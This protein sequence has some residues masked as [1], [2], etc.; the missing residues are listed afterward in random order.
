MIEKLPNEIP[1]YHTN[2]I[3]GTPI[4]LKGTINLTI[5]KINEL[6]DQSNR[7]DEAILELSSMIEWG[8]IHKNSETIRFILSGRKDNL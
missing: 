8:D 4:V 7:Q 5:E 2:L 3:D 6:I 1:N